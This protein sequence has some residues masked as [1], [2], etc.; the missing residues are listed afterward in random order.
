[1]LRTSR[2]LQSVDHHRTFGKPHNK[3]HTKSKRYRCAIILMLGDGS[4]LTTDVEDSMYTESKKLI[5]PLFVAFGGAAIGAFRIEEM[6]GLLLSR[7]H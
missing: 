4:A 5:P 1:M 6:Y 2:I 7:I 3:I